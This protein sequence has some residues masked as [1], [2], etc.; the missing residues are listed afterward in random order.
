MWRHQIEQ[1]EYEAQRAQRQ[2]NAVEPE[3]R[4]VARTLEARW[5]ATLE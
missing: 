1:A 3:N 4:T 5:N 2:Y